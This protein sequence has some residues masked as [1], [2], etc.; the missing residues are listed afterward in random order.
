MVYCLQ[1]RAHLIVKEIQIF[2]LII[3]HLLFIIH[4]LEAQQCAPITRADMS[5][6]IRKMVVNL[7]NKY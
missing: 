3:P 7:I 1:L 4:F 2:S 5:M 6:R